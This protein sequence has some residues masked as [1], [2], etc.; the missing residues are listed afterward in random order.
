MLVVADTSPL[1]YLIWIHSVVTLQQLYRSVLIPREVR[2]ELLAADAPAVVKS[3]ASHLPGWIEVCAT[4]PVLREDPRWQFL[5]LGERAA[6]ALAVARQPSILLIDERKG[7][8]AR[9]GHSR[10]PG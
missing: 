10:D 9:N 5:D 7:A 8:E 1:N 4:D 3:W 2:D 6:L